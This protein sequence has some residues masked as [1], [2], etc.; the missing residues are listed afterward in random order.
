MTLEEEVDFFF[1]PPLPEQASKVRS[2]LHLLRR[3][4]QDCLI[5]TVVP[6]N[7]FIAYPGE[8]HRLF[9]TLMVIMCGIE[10]LGKFYAG[11][12]APG[13]V[14]DRFKSFAKEFILA[15]S[16]APEEFADVLYYGCRNTVIHSFNVR[17]KKKRYRMTIVDKPA[18]GVVWSVPG[19]PDRFVVSVEGLAQAP[20]TPGNPSW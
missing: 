15:G 18:T 5:G 19:Q 11:N 13:G 20:D 3:E 9:A 16:R 4:M 6:E 7:E 17:E 2:T 12:D 8:R 10:L 14:Y 1:A